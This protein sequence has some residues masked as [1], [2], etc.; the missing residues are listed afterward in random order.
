MK[1]CDDT[2]QLA[3]ERDRYVSEDDDC[4]EGFLPFADCNDDACHSDDEQF[5]G[6]FSSPDCSASSLSSCYPFT[7]SPKMPQ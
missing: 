7:H 2:A 5:N 4:G 6:N 3:E 1:H